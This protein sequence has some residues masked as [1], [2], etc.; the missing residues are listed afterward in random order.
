MTAIHEYR[1]FPNV[2]AK[3]LVQARLELPALVAALRVPRGAD[4]LEI[5]CGR[6]V[7]LPVLARLCAPT[8]L[9]GLDIDA[10]LLSEARRRLERTGVEAELVHA[11]AR[12][13]P[14]D[15]ASFD[16]VVDFGTAYHVARP[17]DVLREIGRVLRPGGMFV[18]ERR[19][20]QLLA[21]PIRSLGHALPWRA[22]PDLERQRRA[23]F[24]GTRVRRRLGGADFQDVPA[25]PA[26]PSATTG[27]TEDSEPRS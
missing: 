15:A 19:S 26:R 5:G 2:E 24:W 27:R 7:A 17:E 8:R 22:V 11:D 12:A 4:V 9:V 1:P 20:A 6:G 10:A 25:L 3:N 23:V 14:F 21:H 18:H 16:V 13:L